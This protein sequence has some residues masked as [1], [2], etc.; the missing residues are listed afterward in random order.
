MITPDK[1][2]ADVGAFEWGNND[3]LMFAHG[4]YKCVTGE[5]HPSFPVTPY[6]TEMEAARVLRGVFVQHGVSSVPELF[7]MFFDRCDPRDGA[8]AV[9]ETGRKGI[10]ASHLTGICNSKWSMLT[11]SSKGPVMIPADNAMCWE[12]G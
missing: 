5:D 3:C 7:D 6:R 8:L 11:I 4:W 10:V 1:Y 12:I 9:I 2:V